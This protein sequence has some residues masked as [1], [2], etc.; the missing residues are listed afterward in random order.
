[1]VMTPDTRASRRA[2][3]PETD[4]RLFFESSSK[5]GERDVPPRS[6][7]SLLLVLFYSFPL[8]FFRSSPPPPGS[9]LEAVVVELRTSEMTGTFSSSS[10]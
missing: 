3:D 2:R 6:R 8:F 4:P 9:P 5:R 1:M 10:S 7:C